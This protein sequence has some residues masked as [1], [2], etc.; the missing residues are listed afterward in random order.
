MDIYILPQRHQNECLFP[1]SD[2]GIICAIRILL[3]Q[4]SVDNERIFQKMW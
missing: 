3:V 2:T 4:G 1:F